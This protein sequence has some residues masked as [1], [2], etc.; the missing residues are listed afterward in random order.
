MMRKK[1]LTATTPLSLE[2]EFALFHGRD[3]SPISRKETE[4]FGARLRARLELPGSSLRGMNEVVGEVAGNSLEMKVCF[5]SPL[6][7]RDDVK[8]AY[9]ALA[10]EAAESGLIVIGASQPQKYDGEMNYFFT[11]KVF[12]DAAVLAG[13]N[14]IHLHF[15]AENDEEARR[16]YNTL[17][18][19]APLMLAVSQSSV[20]EGREN[21]RA[22]LITRFMSVIPERMVT[23]W[24]LNSEGSFNEGME[25]AR[26]QAEAR[27]RMLPIE[28]QAR[29]ASDHP[30]LVAM[31]DGSAKLLRL[32]P[33]KIFHLARLRPDKASEERGLVGSVEFRPIDGQV[34]MEHDLGMIELT[35]GLAAYNEARDGMVLNPSEI[36]ALMNALGEIPHR[37][38]MALGGLQVIKSRLDIASAGLREM[39]LEAEYLDAVMDVV[40]RRHDASASPAE[41][42]HSHSSEFT[43]SV[44]C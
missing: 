19:A 17:N 22:Y 1:I 2:R 5:S 16:R 34:R 29:I 38:I 36:N 23:P 4:S 43:A 9:R 10:V 33:D 12:P 7:I 6:R 37:G 18:R 40:T 3:Y 14:S 27:L 13:A 39:G 11:T 35:L 31:E 41:I 21:G 26:I 15:G 20:I 30:E 42:I 28:K 25:L 32:T 24:V 44:R 8:S